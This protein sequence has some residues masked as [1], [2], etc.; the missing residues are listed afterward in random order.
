SKY[1]ERRARHIVKA[2]LCAELDRRRFAAVLS[3]DPDLD[4]R[5]GRAALL[6]RQL[7]ELPNAFAIQHR[8][9]VLLQDAFR[10]IRGQNGANVVA[11]ET[12]RGLGEIVGAEAEELGLLRDL[13]S[14]Q[15]G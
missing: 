6:H 4:G 11:R 15:G 8:K 7:H 12:E 9:R 13:V 1:A 10:K 3:A 5:T 2:E 14:D